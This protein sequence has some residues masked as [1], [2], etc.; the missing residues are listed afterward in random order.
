MPFEE[1]DKAVSSLSDRSRSAKRVGNE[2]LVP[3]KFDEEGTPLTAE[4]FDIRLHLKTLRQTDYQFLDAWRESGWNTDKAKEKLGLNDG[5]VARL[6]K[7]LEVF[8]EEEARAL[9]LAKIPTPSWIAAK[10]V[11]NIYDGGQL[12]DSERDSLKELA[13]ISGAYK[14]AATVNIQNNIFNMPKLSEEQ[15][16]KLRE[17]ADSQA[18]V[19]EGEIAA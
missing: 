12:E 9:Q 8:R 5:Q 14:T 11:E 2:V 6:V 19:V 16:A 15:M 13:K 17:F 10:H 7:K 1:A 3:L 4:T 18:N